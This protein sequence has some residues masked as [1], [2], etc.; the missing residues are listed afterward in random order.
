MVPGN[1]DLLSYAVDRSDTIQ[2]CC[3]P[4]IWSEAFPIA[5]NGT[6]LRAVDRS[7]TVIDCLGRQLHVLLH[8]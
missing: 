6:I 8:V 1:T 2:G 5:G 7:D 4:K 3:R